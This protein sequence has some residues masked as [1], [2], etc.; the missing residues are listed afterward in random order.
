M[1]SNT[2]TCLEGY[3]FQF[4]VT[5][6]ITLMLWEQADLRVLPEEGEDLRVQYDALLGGCID[7]QVKSTQRPLTVELLANILSRFGDSQAEECTFD[8]LLAGQRMLVI[9]GGSCTSAVERYRCNHGEFDATPA[10]PPEAARDILKALPTA[11]TQADSGTHLDLERRKHLAS[12]GS[13]KVTRGQQAL[14]RM[15]VWDRGAMREIG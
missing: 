13:W 9:V 8:R 2:G 14:R 5:V 3:E 11:K 1:S 7:V 15:S 4:L 6:W 12:L 10:V